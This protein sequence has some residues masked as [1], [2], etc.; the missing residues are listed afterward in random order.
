MDRPNLGEGGSKL[1][2]CRV[3]T[4]LQNTD[5]QMDALRAAGCWKI[6]TDHASGAKEDR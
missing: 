5:L 4:G 6:F 1:G 2:Y 3:S